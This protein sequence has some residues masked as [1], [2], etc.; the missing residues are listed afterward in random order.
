MSFLDKIKKAYAFSSAKKLVQ[1]NPILKPALL[2]ARELRNIIDEDS[3]EKIGSELISDIYKIIESNN[4]IVK[5]REF[6]AKDVMQLANYGVLL[7]PPEPEEDF[8]GL[9]GTQG[10]TGELKAHIYEIGQKDNLLKQVLYGFYENPKPEDVLYMV[11]LFY[12]KYFF[13]TEVFDACRR[14][15]SDCNQIKGRDWYR[16]FVHAMFVWKESG[17]REILDMPQAIDR[18]GTDD[19]N[20]KKIHGLSISFAYSSFYDI[21]LSGVKFP[22]LEWKDRFSEDF[23]KDFLEPV[24]SDEKK[25]ATDSPP[26]GKEES[27]YTKWYENGQKKSTLSY[28]NGELEGLSTFWYENGKIEAEQ[29]YK[30]GKLVG[31]NEW[32]E[33]GKEWRVAKFKN[34]KQEGLCV[35]WY[36]NGHK[37]IEGIYRDGILIETIYKRGILENFLKSLLGM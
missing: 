13:R 2:R 8:S 30:N 25:V 14:E 27:L 15:L 23:K 1:E 6:L 24:Y 31:I 18:P 9:R 26:D 20:M 29:N 19:Q 35:A 21:V 16:P 10:V 5:C 12:R 17:Y 22:D 4:Q 28:K 3:R 37:K 34:E 36:K 7:I 11:D 33:D 32:Y